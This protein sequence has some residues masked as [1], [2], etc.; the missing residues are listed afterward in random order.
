MSKVELLSKIQNL[1]NLVQGDNLKHYELSEGSV[2]EL[3][4]ALDKMTDEYIKIYC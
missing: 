1:T 3:R 2:A 4:Q